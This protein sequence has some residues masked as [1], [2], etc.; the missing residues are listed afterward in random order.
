MVS[1][2]AGAKMEK[3]A[4]DILLYMHCKQCL[5]EKPANIS[6]KNW[7]SISVGWTKKGIQVWCIR[8]ERNIINLDFKGQKVG[9]L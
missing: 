9:T 8:H 1:V 4:N 2:G 5:E 7:A 6:P 3:A